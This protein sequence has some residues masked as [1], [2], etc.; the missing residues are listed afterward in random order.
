MFAIMMQGCYNCAQHASGYLSYIKD[1]QS[2]QDL[3]NNY[4]TG[5]NTEKLRKRNIKSLEIL[6][7][8]VILIFK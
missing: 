6:G 5:L 3:R 2:Y 7:F 1:L 4:Y 8:Q